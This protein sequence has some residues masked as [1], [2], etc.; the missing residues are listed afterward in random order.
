MTPTSDDPP[1]DS[2]NE[3]AAAAP[4]PKPFPSDGR[5]LGLDYGQ[6]RVGIAIST[7]EQSIASP[8]DNYQRCT[9]EIDAR[10]LRKLAD[11]YRV[12][13]IVV[14]LPVHLNGDE[15]ESARHAREYGAW[16]Q[17]VTGLP[18]T[19]WDERFTT[20]MAE[21]HLISVDMSR[22]KR[23]AR[24]DKL[25]AMFLLQSFLDAPDR[26]APPAPLRD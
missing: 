22:K 15:G 18:I 10:M 3:S 23:A 25:A 11:E 4:A 17:S 5:L 6:K 13:G 8:L 19:F 14:G 12:A 21:E 9:D 16:V 7:P 20:A 1:P 2:G 24:R 26:S